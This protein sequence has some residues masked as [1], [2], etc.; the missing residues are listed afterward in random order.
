MSD[1][2][3]TGTLRPY[4][5][6]VVEDDV[7]Q[8]GMLCRYLEKQGLAVTP[9]TTAEEMLHR[10]HRMRP[11]LIVLGAGLAR[12]SGFDA[13]RKLKAEGDRVPIILLTARS[14]PVDRVLGLEMGA[15]D[16][17]SRPFLDRELL[18]RVRAVLRRAAFTPGAPLASRASIRI[19]EHVFSVADRSLRRGNDM[20]VLNA[21]EYAMLAELATNAGITV[22]RERLVAVSHTHEDLVSLRAVDTAIVRLR[23]AVE[24][25][26]A[27][28]RY[29]QTVRGHG[30]V[31]VPCGTRPA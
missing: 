11:D 4:R 25:D 1:I 24:P 30:Y 23:R 16:C 6:F 10:I 5:L 20:R 18:A 7:V 22:S 2:D 14:E 28:P 9:M 13:C 29:I 19:G 8:R 26:P 12:M 3:F 15:D 27:A 17:L 21:V 31:F